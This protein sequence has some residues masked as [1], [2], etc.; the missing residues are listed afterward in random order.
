M[1]HVTVFRIQHRCYSDLLVKKL[2]LGRTLAHL[3]PSLGV[4]PCEYTLYRQELSGILNSE[5]RTIVRS[6]VLTQY[7]RV[8]D[9][10]THR[11]NCCS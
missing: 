1:S 6:F 4:I 10:E 2:P 8:T 11:Q 3:M 7:R 9:R 5:D